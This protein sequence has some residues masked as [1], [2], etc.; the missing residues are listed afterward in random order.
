MSITTIDT[1]SDATVIS[2][3]D[4]VRAELDLLIARLRRDVWLSGL[5]AVTA[6]AVSLLLASIVLDAV[7]E[8]EST[9]WRFVLWIPVLAASVLATWRFVWCPLRDRCNRLA[10]A[11][12]LEENR[13]ELQERL[14]STLLLAESH[15]SDATL[16]IDAVA[17]QANRDLVSC[18]E[19]AATRRD[20]RPPAIAAA[21]CLV[22]TAFCF[23]VWPQYLIPSLS[24]VMAPWNTRQLPYL[25]AV[26]LPGHTS[27]AEGQIL[28]VSAVGHGLNECVLEFMDDRKVLS[29]APMTF[30]ATGEAASVLLPE[31]STDQIYR[32]RSGSL[33]SDVYQITVHPRPVVT[34][35]K[36]TLQF[37]EY[38]GI[39]QATIDDL[40]VPIAA[41]PGTQVKFSAATLIPTSDARLTLGDNQQGVAE[42]S[43][44][45]GLWRHH[46]NLQID[47][48]PVQL[49]CLNLTSDHGVPSEPFR[50]E[51]Q[52]VPD[53]APL[54]SIRTPTLQHVA[55]S[56]DGELP[57]QFEAADD[58]GLTSVEV[59]LQ[60]GDAEP[61]RHVILQNPDA[62]KHA[63]EY[64]FAPQEH[65]LKADDQLMLWFVAA[66]NRPQQYGGVQ[67]G[68]S[69]RLL[70]SIA[71]DAASLGR[72][73]V[74]NEQN[75]ILET[76]S[77]AIVRLRDAKETAQQI[78]DATKQVDA[79]AAGGVPA[80]TN[81][82]A[83][84]LQQELQ[85]AQQAL[86]NV[87]KSNES[88]AEL[89]EAEKLQVRDIADREVEEA[90]QQA[91]M[92][93]L[94]NDPVARQQAAD[95]ARSAVEQAEEQLQALAEQLQDRAE[96]LKQAAELD[97]LARQQ[98]ALAEK[99]QA[100]E[101]PPQP[102]DTKQEQIADRLQELVRNNPE[103]ESEQFLQRADTAEQLAEKTRQ[104]HE[105]QQQLASATE[106]K[107]DEETRRRLARMIQTEQQ[108]IAAEN[109]QLTKE[110]QQQ[111]ANRADDKAGAEAQQLM[112]QVMNDLA[113][114]NLKA[115]RQN[116]ERAKQKLQE[117][118]TP[119]ETAENDIRQ[120]QTQAGKE[121]RGRLA[122]RQ[123]R[124]E[125]AI[126]AAEE[127]DFEAAADELQKLITDRL[128]QATKE[129]EELLEL[130]TD[131]EENQQLARKTQQELQEALKQSQQASDTPEGKQQKE[132]SEHREAGTQPEQ[133]ADATK[134]PMGPQ[135]EQQPV[136]QDMNNDQPQTQKPGDQKKD[137]PAKQNTE[138]GQ[139]K[140]D[141]NDQRQPGQQDK[142]NG[143]P[144]AQKPGGQKK[145]QPAKQ[146]TEAGQQKDE[147]K[148][149]RQSGQQDK[150]NGQP[151]AQKP[152][153]QKEG[154]AAEQNE[155]D[156]KNAQPQKPA[157]A[158]QQE[159]DPRSQ[160]QQQAR[161]QDKENGQ[162]EARQAD[163][164]QPQ[165]R[166]K[167]PQQR[168][169]QKE[170]QKKKAAQSLQQATE[171]LQQFCKSCRK[172]A[173]CN[174]PG[175]SES[176]SGNSSPG[177]KQPGGKQ[178]GDK[179][180]GDKQPGQ[181]RQEKFGASKQL[182][183][184]TDHAQKAARNPTPG[185]AKQLAKELDQLADD[186]ARNSGSPR[187]PGNASESDPEQN[188]NQP[189][190]ANADNKSGRPD[191]KA[192]SSGQP[193]GVGRNG[194]PD[195][196]DTQVTQLRG[197]STSEWTRSHKR[198]RGNVLD[199]K[200]TQIPEAYRGVVEDY[201]EQ[202]SKI[203]SD[204]P[205]AEVSR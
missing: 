180:P 8:P 90:Q 110:A 201:F 142:N 20:L 143:Q 71:D 85:D 41:V 195:D 38:T 127:N 96:K 24:N 73:Q 199:R 13:P 115:A 35:V 18:R 74:T 56:P 7:F 177:N 27:I 37:P 186:A 168:D 65:G 119:Q 192:S 79:D 63:A 132:A 50:F 157:D 108:A 164:K 43:Q 2:A 144:Q 150:N 152:G 114:Q 64:V 46:W 49:G 92:I 69:R 175:Q 135:A 83:M 81:P 128:Q 12:S 51:I 44:D 200:S 62:A 170:Q 17:A 84:K 59:L 14:T 82:N 130:P 116:A 121:E 100:G 178:P 158:E 160:Q 156:Q 185:A 126:Q 197:P 66:D 53:E 98:N 16:L 93:P 134:L 39:P 118:A 171:S 117:A 166:P 34:D 77:D 72:Q 124:I 159:V 70:I 123:E 151:Q 75:Q 154:P 10:L 205:K 149:Q 87:T 122:E 23:A 174:K 133:P 103:A 52:S 76:L 165:A 112:E 80:D 36:A 163:R 58:Y 54:V 97:E 104:L 30:A 22:I 193:M 194:Q 167:D 153:D 3:T 187:R 190:Q 42:T 113:E 138:A 203:Q 196:V 176:A 181:N 68:E 101:P 95:A 161:Q 136:P 99:M 184:T 25:S 19:D 188:E 86:D 28:E 57:I 189:K 182:A 145:D 146:N 129:A 155:A 169:S 60:M 147:L 89:F 162:P 131:D 140:D 40:S 5:L 88:G 29:S 102:T 94:T 45:E 21:S 204:D 183:A 48:Q 6:T 179:Q 78:A 67:T 91:R 106:K 120:P 148:D 109:Q 202:L 32:V 139:Q 111:Q 4:R 61:Q 191:G 172:C 15:Q 141:P 107:S 33:V 105:Q 198:L 11:W 137:Q 31:L 173:N 47:E 9:G 55:V 1:R 26:I 125:H